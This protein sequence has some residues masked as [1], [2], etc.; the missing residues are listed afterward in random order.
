[1]TRTIQINLS[2]N[3]DDIL[4]EKATGKDT[5]ETL[6]ATIIAEWCKPYSD[7]KEAEVRALLASNEA[8]VELGKRVAA[9]SPEKQAAAFQAVEKALG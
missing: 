7:V 9:A 8:L 3:L 5:P 6:C 4:I 1:M 2:K